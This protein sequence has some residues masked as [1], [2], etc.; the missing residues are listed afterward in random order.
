MVDSQETRNQ[1]L[2][3]IDEEWVKTL[4]T[5]FSECSVLVDDFS[6]LILNMMRMI[7]DVCS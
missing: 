1:L 2:K 7:Y 3:V 5:K 4:N 6:I